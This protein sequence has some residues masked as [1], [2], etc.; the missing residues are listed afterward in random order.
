MMHPKAQKSELQRQRNKG[1][2]HVE[3]IVYTRSIELD[4]PLATLVV[5]QELW[6]DIL[7]SAHKRLSRFT[8][9]CIRLVAEHAG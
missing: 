4:T 1:V 8:C 5:F 2:R 9:G 6:G 3:F 7:G